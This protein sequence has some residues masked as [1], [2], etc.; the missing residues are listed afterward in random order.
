MSRIAQAPHRRPWRHRWLT[1]LS[2]SVLVSVALYLVVLISADAGKVLASA[3]RLPLSG[4]AA[5]L[6]LSLLNYALRFLRWHFY[7][8][9][10]GHRLP[11][12][13][14]A[15]IYCSGFALTTTPGKAGE[16]IRSL[17]LHALGVP[18]P[19]SLAALFAERMMDLLSMLAL[20]G[21]GAVALGFSRAWVLLGLAACIGVVLLVR[22]P[23]MLDFVAGLQLKQARL[24]HW[25]NHF[26]HLLKASSALLRPRLLLAAV[27]LGALSWG[28]EGVGLHV[29]TEALGLHTSQQLALGI[30]ALAMLGGA[31]SLVPGGLGGA[32]AVMGALLVASGAALPDAVAATLI[33]RAATLWFAILLG[34]IAMGILQAEKSWATTP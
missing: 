34:M 20:A 10:L 18:Y 19:H 26:V 31:A 24:A 9:A 2:L 22:N 28:A 4:W 3:R 7:L 29:I 6:S 14:D 1:A 27:A 17:Y 8:R 12:L 30:Y 16:A 33:C 13:R 25:R 32:E 15:A 23:R 11:R 5:I 21:L